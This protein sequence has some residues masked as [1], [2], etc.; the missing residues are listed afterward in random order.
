MTWPLLNRHFSDSQCELFGWVWQYE[1]GPSGDQ[2]PQGQARDTN[3]S[4]QASAAEPMQTA[5]SES[6]TKVCHGPLSVALMAVLYC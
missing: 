5:Q 1:R 3:R 2:V 6:G 4:A